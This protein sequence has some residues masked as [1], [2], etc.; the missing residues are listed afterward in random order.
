M[1]K[2]IIAKSFSNGFLAI[3]KADN[4]TQAVEKYC[5]TVN[6]SFTDLCNFGSARMA[7]FYIDSECC[8]VREFM[9]IEIE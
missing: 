5:T 2:Y 7:E 3:V 1:K 9:G 4:Y 8:Y 6:V